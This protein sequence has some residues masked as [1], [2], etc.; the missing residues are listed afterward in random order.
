M[1]GRSAFLAVRGGWLAAAL[2]LFQ[3]SSHAGTL[4]KNASG[5]FSVSTS[6]TGF[7]VDSGGPVGAPL[8]GTWTLPPGAATGRSVGN[9]TFASENGQPT[10]STRGSM[11]VGGGRSAPMDFK[12]P[13]SRPSA[14]AAMGKFVGKVATPLAVGMALYDLAKDLG[15]TAELDDD[16][17]GAKFYQIQ[18]T[19]YWYIQVNGT[20]NYCQNVNQR[21][22]SVSLNGTVSAYLA[23]AQQC[24]NG[25]QSYSV[26]QCYESAGYCAINI[27]T[28]WNNQD[29]PAN[30]S[31]T[32]VVGTEDKVYAPWSYIADT[33]LASGGW[34]DTANGVLVDAIKSGE[35]VEV[36]EPT[37]TG[38]ASVSG[39][40]TTTTTPT[41]DGGKTVTSTTTD[42]KISYGPGPS[43]SITNNSTST[44]TTYNSSNV[45]TN[46][47]NPT[48]TES[49]PEQP[50]DP[51]ELNPDSVGCMK[52]GTPDEQTLAKDTKG[53]TITPADFSGGT[54]PAPISFT[55]FDRSY[56][57]SYD[58]LCQK[59]A[60][61]GTL[62]L[63]LAGLAAA[64]IFADGFKV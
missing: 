13:V 43:Y 47:S 36:G 44:T 18:S 5:G 26:L 16:G 48:T 52:L 46:V 61:L 14:L 59:L 20:L 31:A 9:F 6:A 60:L 23:Y 11:P 54:C 32:K 25:E 2:V 55:A 7:T 57:F 51:C 12:T 10:A 53:V 34:A 63:A 49:T 30:V 29:V 41:A 8:R 27:H 21:F 64:Y 28:N 1:H 50:K 45:V 35:A 37:I 24:G 56:S 15:Y 40:T 39:P 62:F 38:P 3:L 58:P 42:Y 33:H 4:T 22:Q 19:S 17:E